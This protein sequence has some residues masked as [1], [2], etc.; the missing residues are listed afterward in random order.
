MFKKN[1]VNASEV[2]ELIIKA[3]SQL[4][5]EKDSEQ[6]FK[7]AFEA[8]RR[9]AAILGFEFVCF[10]FYLVY[11]DL[12]VNEPQNA[13]RF[14]HDVIDE[15][16]NTL[17]AMNPDGFLGLIHLKNDV[18]E[19][20]FYGSWVQLQPKTQK[21]IDKNHNIVQLKSLD[22]ESWLG[23]L[24]LIYYAHISLALL[25]NKEEFDDI[26]ELLK[27]YTYCSATAI[28]F[29]NVFVDEFKKFKIKF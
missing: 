20:Y 6:L 7:R 29:G 2:S 3:F 28:G 23:Q 8:S 22:E 21:W 24:T 16:A 14:M 10:W 4:L 5:K 15:T 1:T 25:D 27:I 19:K 9:T 13:N 11:A 12:K 26:G 18:L 17:D